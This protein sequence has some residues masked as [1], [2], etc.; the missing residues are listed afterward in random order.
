MTRPRRTL[1]A[2]PIALAAVASGALAQADFAESFEN[3]GV[4]QGNGPVNLV[5][6][7][8]I[9]R[10]Q[11]D[12]VNGSAWFDGTDFGGTPF[13]GT[14][15]LAADGLAT[16]FLGG[17]YSVWAILP[18]IP[19]QTAGDEFSIWVQYGGS[20]TYDTFFE[21]RYAP[22]GSG[23]GSGPD[24]V[25]DFTT[26]LFE[27]EMP[28]AST[29]YQRVSAELPGPGRIALR[30]RADFLMTFAGRGA[31]L[32]VDALTVGPAPAA[33]CGVPIPDPGES[34]VWSAAEAPYTVCQ[35]LLIPEGAQ[36]MVE[37]GAEISFDPGTTLRVEGELIA[38]GSPTDPVRFT[39]STSINDGLEIGINGQLDVAFGEV[40]VHVQAGG[41]G[42]AAI[43]TDTDFV[44]GSSI[45]GI[46]DIA[47]FERCDFTGASEL[48]SFGGLAGSIRISD[49]TFADGA[50]MRVT[51]LVRVDNVT[52]EGTGLVIAGE[53][54]AHPV[55]ID[56]ISV[57]GVSNAAGLTLSGPNYLLGGNVTLQGNVY[58]VRLEG[59]GAGLMWGST[60]PTSGNLNNAVSVDQFTPGAYRQWANTGLPYIVQGEFPQNF[61]GSLLVEP[62]TNIK[63]GPGA[64][65]FLI[66]SSDISLQGTREQPIL[67]ESL[68][69]GVNRWFGLKWVDVF[70]AKAR[71]TIFDG[72]EITIQSDGGVMDLVNCT[73]RNSLEGTASVTGG[74]VRLY[75]SKIVNNNVGMVTTTS[76]RVEADG[77]ISPS[78]FE[79]NSVAVDYNNTNGTTPFLR[80]NWWGDATGPT[81]SLNPGG[82]GDVVQD[83]HPAAFTPF[84]AAP[85]AQDDE[86]PI[87]DMEPT[88]WFANTGGKILL[89]WSSSDDDEVVAHR[90]EFADHDFPSQFMTVA[91]LPGDA[92]TYEFTAPTVL[93]TNQYPT[94]SAIRIVA[95]DSAGQESWDK[96]VLRIPYHEDWTVVPQEV[97]SPGD[98][99]PHD[100]IDVCWSPGGLGDAYVLMDGIR[101]S[102]SAGGSNTGCLPIGAGLPYSSTDTAR[103]VIV[104]TFARAGASTTPS[105]TT[106]PSAP[107]HASATSPRRSRPPPP[108]RASSSPA[109]A[110]S[111]SAGP[112]PTT[113]PS[114]RSPSRPATTAGRGWHSVARD[115]P[116]DARAFDWRLP[117]SDGIADVRVRVVAFDKRFQESSSTT[118][119]FEILA[120]DAGGCPADL[121]EPFA[122]LDFSD[123][124]AFLTAFGNMDPAADFAT[125][126]GQFDFSDVVA[127]LTA[128]GAGCP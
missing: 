47:V 126:I 48:G 84:L 10:N 3:N 18:E 25:G 78:I 68:S 15:Y 43:F 114:A 128:F 89:R 81:S 63:F 95:V 34:I 55:F 33:P 1:L 96:S 127:F 82:M 73:V 54:I 16:D 39:G 100:N 71:H 117:A 35:D 20:A 91:N 98:V 19:D 4:D 94:P 104:T 6:Q 17:D 36:V 86:F 56:N 2:A 116:A 41:E 85:P 46:P 101:L 72:G 13:D 53:T 66:G 52:S 11:C 77:T 29:G 8:W 5:A 119:A 120:G 67:I 76:G 115:L 44:A 57:T 65:A 14:G 111:P 49:S 58:P 113:R 50:G 22:S 37:P 7:G 45:A 105:P 31:N 59:A 121:A 28:L 110:S 23:T 9:F 64:G 80:F 112:P 97:F 107:M 118:G 26:V 38:T 51:G 125:P 108:L 42:V 27:A 75:N 74:I 21:V 123:V 124:V 92:T 122:Q 102:K 30:F 109:A 93:P 61:G 90:V 62:G 99:H 88:Y 12:P 32:D 60:L 83:V 24:D 87:V 70:D 79:G 69:P 106:S 40:A 103:I